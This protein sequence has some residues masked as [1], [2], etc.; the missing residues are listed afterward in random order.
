MCWSLP[1]FEF[2]P[3]EDAQEHFMA[4]A[5]NKRREEKAVEAPAKKEKETFS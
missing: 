4:M 3:F 5:W 1:G 2:D